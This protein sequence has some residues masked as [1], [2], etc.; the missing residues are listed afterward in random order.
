MERYVSEIFLELI[1]LFTPELDFKKNKFTETKR[2][3]LTKELERLII[4]SW[5]HWTIEM[6]LKVETVSSIVGR[7]FLPTPGE[8]AHQPQWG[9]PWISPVTGCDTVIPQIMAYSEI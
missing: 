7:F 4:I 6:L 8:G 1:K 3:R 2:T 9:L 5:Q